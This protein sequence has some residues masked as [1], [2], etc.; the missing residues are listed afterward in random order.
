MNFCVQ[1]TRLF[2]GFAL[3]FAQSNK[4]TSISKFEVTIMHTDK[5]LPLPSACVHV[6]ALQKMG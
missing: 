3:A 4:R 2:R 1:L 6:Y 5:M